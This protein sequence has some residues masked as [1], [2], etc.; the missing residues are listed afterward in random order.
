MTLTTQAAY[1]KA[2]SHSLATWQKRRA[3]RLSPERLEAALILLRLDLDPL[4]PM[5]VTLYSSSPRG[6]PPWEPLAMFRALLLMTLLRYQ[7]L[8]LFAK[9]LRQQPRLAI[10]AGFEPNRTPS[11][12]ALYLFIDRLENGPFQPACPH[13]HHPSDLRKGKHLR[14]LAQEKAEKEAARKRILAACDSIT[15]QLKHDLLAID[16]LPRPD[17]LQKRLEDSLLQLAVLPSAQR[18]LLG[19]LEGLILCGDGSSLYSGASPYG[20]PT[21]HCRRQGI[22]NC[23]CDR[24]FSDPT[25]NWGWDSYR[26]CYYF[27][28]TFYQHVVSCSG[29]DL[30]VHL[31]IGQASESD[32]TL[33]IKSLD[34]FFKTCSEN[35]LPVK[36]FAAGYD[37][38]H[39]G[40]GNYE[41]L[42]AKGIQPVI[43]LNPRSG[44]HPNPT[45]TAERITDNGIPL[46]PAG[47]EMRRHTVTP[48]HRI[49]Y[50]CPVKRPTH[51]EG[52]H[53]WK[54][55]VDECP[56]G[57]LC[58]P[59]TKMGP[60]VY[61]RSD[62]DPRFYPEIARDSQ[63]YTKIMNLRSGCER[64]N[65]VKKVV[66]HLGD[67]PC[68]SATHYLVRLYLVSIIEHAK[69][70]LA[71]DRKL[72]GEDWKLLS[73][74]EQIRQLAQPPPG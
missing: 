53:V 2:L 73:D 10:L 25:A 41:Y 67:R 49:I 6:R 3:R 21:C 4:I 20:K 44:T 29:H 48:N 13:R 61:V 32:F 22:F 56:H 8:P 58:Q 5:L 39:D 50:H 74:P 66:H 17:D 65:S 40:L 38:G 68:R 62:L 34:R 9:E 59:E 45:G 36:V 70:W 28:H 11:A 37:S 46:C 69:A 27:G 7:S 15:Q 33:S 71:E 1:Q 26:E 47:L 31:T 51:I 18:G 12:S 64:S 60:S 57:V 72:L 52:K 24:F 35:G 42:R 54:A 19:D 55:H 16:H 14:N 30:P 43:A 63:Q 23:H